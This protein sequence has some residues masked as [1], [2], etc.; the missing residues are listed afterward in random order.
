VQIG[1]QCWMQQ[2]MNFETDDSWCYANDPE[3]CETFGRLYNHNAAV[4]A[5]PDGWHL[6]DNDEWCQL[7]TYLDP[8]VNCETFGPTGADAGGKMKSTGVYEQGGLWYEPN[9]GATNE[10]GF[11]GLPGGFYHDGGFNH[12]HIEARFW[13]AS[14]EDEDWFFL[15][16]LHHDNALVSRLTEHYSLGFSVRCL[17][18]VGLPSVSTAEV[19]NITSSSAISGGDALD[20]GG[21]TV[22]ARGVVWSNTENPTLEDNKGFTDDGEG[23]GEFVSAITGLT[24]EITYY[25]RAYATNSKGTAYGNELIFTTDAG[26]FACG[27]IFI[28]SRDGQDYATV[29]IGDQCWMQQNMNFETDDSWCYAN[30]PENC[31]TFGRLY[32]H[33]AAE[34]VCPEGWHLPANDEWCQLTTYLDETIDCNAFGPTGT[35]AGG[36]MKSTG[37]LGDGGLWNAPNTG[38]TNESSFTGLPGGFMHDGNFWDK[39]VLARFWSA[40]ESGTDWYYFWGMQHNDAQVVRSSEAYTFGFSVRCIKD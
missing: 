5:C 13:S 20:G 27:G 36:K 30:D 23:T 11:T 32:N 18:D 16:A 15:W 1:D 25:V 2:N 21:A 22:T 19:T 39:H 33:N 3:N 8:T 37:I 40:T 28:D 24:P 34:E 4:Q 14:A 29:Q 26:G 38:A 7:T 17:R 6:P 31:E 9:T 10:S 12:Q 35:D